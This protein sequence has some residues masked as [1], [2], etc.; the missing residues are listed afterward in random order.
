M[1]TYAI[2]DVQGCHEELVALLEAL[3]FDR[4]RDR[5]ILVGD[6]VNRGPNSLGVLR[7]VRDLGD[8]A[9]TVL[10]NHDLHLLAVAHGGRAGRRDTLTGVLAASDC[11]ELLD[12][13]ARQ[14]LAWC[15]EQTGY[16]F[17]HAG[18]PPQWTAEQTLA[19]A[20]EASALIRGPD[21]PR[22]FSRMY[23][24][25]PERWTDKLRVQDRTRFVVN[26]L[27]RLRYCHADGRLDL[28]PK[29]APGTQAGDVM[30]WFAV[31]DRATRDTSMVFGH[32]STLGRVHWPEHRVHGLDTGCVWGGRLTALALETGELI[33]VPSRNPRDP[34]EPGE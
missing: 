9:T 28:R 25:D 8:A 14:P 10:G 30:P 16:L 18:V 1:T 6:L 32:W 34:E 23:G 5:V 33:D 2:G 3:E 20:A 15:H 27:T 24:D 29:G 22:F 12:W 11:D 19:L 7:L 21:G 17:V 4:A 13:L 31:P 26:C